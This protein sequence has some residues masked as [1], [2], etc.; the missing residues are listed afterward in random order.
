M[1]ASGSELDRLQET[2]VG[3][4]AEWTVQVG[5]DPTSSQA[6]R[7]NVARRVLGDEGLRAEIAAAAKV[8]ARGRTKASDK[9]GRGSRSGTHI[10][11]QVEKAV[12][13]PTATRTDH[14]SLPGSSALK[15]QLPAIPTF[16]RSAPIVG[17]DLREPTPADE[18]REIPV[19][20]GWLVAGFLT[21][22]A[23]GVD[24]LDAI[25]RLANARGVPEE[26]GNVMWFV[27][28]FTLPLTAGSFALILAGLLGKHRGH[29]GWTVL[30]IIG[31]TL[32]GAGLL[33]SLLG[34][35]YPPDLGAGGQGPGPIYLL[36]WALNA[37]MNAYG[38]FLLLASVA[39]GAVAAVQVERW[40]H[41][42]D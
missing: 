33:S 31:A 13:S 4:L 20:W 2:A 12:R 3:S 23:V 36:T 30:G 42:S 18:L 17:S 19:L 5:R 14:S 11:R 35:G 34:L 9:P 39:L 40:G 10:L 22:L 41:G 1:V 24:P 16:P 29:D 38:Y 26:L 7:L 15:S 28:G 6:G 25:G 21:Y 8:P 27:G 37:Y 32:L